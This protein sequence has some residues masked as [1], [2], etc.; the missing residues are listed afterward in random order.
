V[1]YLTK[2]CPICKQKID[3]EHFDFVTET[4]ND[5]EKLELWMAQKWT[6]EMWKK[7]Q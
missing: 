3:N 7:L 5:P 6:F 4:V 2:D 1:Q